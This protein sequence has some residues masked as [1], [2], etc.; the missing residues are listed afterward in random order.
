MKNWLTNNLL[1]IIVLITVI[2]LAARSCKND[3][4]FGGNNTTRK[5]DTIY[6]SHTEYIQ[7]PPVFIPQ[8][9]PQ[10][11]GSQQPIIIPSQYK[12]DTTMTGV[13]RQY[14]DVLS[15]YLTKNT[16][17]DSIVLKD[18]SGKRVG[19]VKLEDQISENKFTSRKPSYDLTFPTITNTTT[20]TKYAPQKWQMYVGGILEGSKDKPLSAGGIG[21]LYK[22]K[23]DAVWML[24][25][26]YNFQQ[27]AM[28]YELARY[29]KLSFEH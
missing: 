15:R 20:I 10:Q 11:I 5:A 29:F 9:I 3:S 27:K 13:L 24:N 8:Y 1:S 7:Q 12:P 25:G 18:T 26:K 4:L 2:V 19:V 28:S 17:M 23:K 21:L 14:V 6:S 22:S 16:Y